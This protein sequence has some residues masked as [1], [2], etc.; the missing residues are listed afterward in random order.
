MVLPPSRGTPEYR[1]W[2]QGATAETQARDAG[3]SE[4]GL[5]VR[6]AVDV[7]AEHRHELSRAD[8]AEYIFAIYTAELSW[9]QRLRAVWRAVRP[10][11]SPKRR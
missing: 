10:V 1:W 5:D 3:R 6:E 8:I 2:E 4:A 9:W 7:L 11:R